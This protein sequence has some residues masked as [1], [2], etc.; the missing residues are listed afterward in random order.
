[1]KVIMN[2]SDKITV[3]HEG[4]IIAVGDPEEIQRNELVRR[5]YLGGGASR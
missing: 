4:E 1:M 3:F 2:I 5:V